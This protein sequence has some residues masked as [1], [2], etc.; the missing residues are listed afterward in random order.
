MVLRSLF[1]RAFGLYDM[2]LALLRRP[3]H[4][5]QGITFVDNETVGRAPRADPAD[6]T[7][8]RR[9]TSPTRWLPIGNR[10][11]PGHWVVKVFD[12]FPNLCTT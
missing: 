3:P 1:R 6:V 9:K 4:R 12:L 11:M 5:P 7:I 10:T 2:E 8:Y